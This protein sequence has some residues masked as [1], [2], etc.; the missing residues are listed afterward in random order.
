MRQL[1]RD[2]S[3]RDLRHDIHELS[4][5]AQAHG[6]LFTL[7]EWP[8]REGTHWLTR[9]FARFVTL[10]VPRIPRIGQWLI[11]VIGPPLITV[12]LLAGL[13]L[14]PDRGFLAVVGLGVAGWACA[15]VVGLYLLAFPRSLRDI[16]F[17]RGWQ[18]PEVVFWGLTLVGT[19][20]FAF[21]ICSLLVAG[22]V[23]DA[24]E[25]RTPW[26]AFGH[27]LW[28]FTDAIPALAI[29][30]ALDWRKPKLF[31]G[32]AAGV[33]LIFYKLLLI[34]P[35]FRLAAGFLKARLGEK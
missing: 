19:V 10:G 33:A 3:W 5:Q 28:H 2:S 29:P 30:D 27:Y 35:L 25:E 7:G 1:L 31:V 8:Q 16:D 17:I 13:G 18:T 14:F 4:R 24:G 15:L 12:L 32:T 11:G 22:P 26:L 20:T 34:V 9:A 6:V 21:A 23:S